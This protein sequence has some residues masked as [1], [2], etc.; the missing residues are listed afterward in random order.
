[1][2]LKA[3]PH[4]LHNTLGNRHVTM[5][6]IGGTIGTGLFLGSGMVV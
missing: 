1:M 4:R 2:Q 5:I 3:E 6:A